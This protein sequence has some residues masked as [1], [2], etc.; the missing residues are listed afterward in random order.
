MHTKKICS[1][2]SR[3]IFQNIQGPYDNLLSRLNVQTIHTD[4][5]RS[6]AS[7][8]MGAYNDPKFWPCIP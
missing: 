8:L 5:L 1:P 7:F 2:L 6:D 3:K 4:R